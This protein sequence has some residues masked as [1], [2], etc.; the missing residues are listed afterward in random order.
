MGRPTYA[1]LTAVD[2]RRAVDALVRELPQVPAL[3]LNGDEAHTPRGVSL[4][5]YCGPDGI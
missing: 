5:N 3:A 4:T 2:G 1:P